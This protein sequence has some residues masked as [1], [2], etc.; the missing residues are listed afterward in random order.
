[1]LF[2]RKAST[3]HL[4][5]YDLEGDTMREIREP[6]ERSHPQISIIPRRRRAVFRPRRICSKKRFALGG[7]FHI[8]VVIL[9]MKNAR[10]LDATAVMAL[11]ALLKFLRTDNRLLLISAR[12][13]T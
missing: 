5:E 10:H 6:S 7:R 8:R 11:E 13:R 3:P 9:R 1:V 12:R 2:L 4:V